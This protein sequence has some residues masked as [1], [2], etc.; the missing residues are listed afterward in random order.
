[1]AAQRMY[2]LAYPIGFL[3]SGMVYVA[4]CEVWPVPGGVSVREH[5]KV[6]GARVVG[7]GY[8]GGYGQGQLDG[9]E[10]SQQTSSDIEK[11]SADFKGLRTNSNS[12]R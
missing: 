2:I 12:S 9:A 5:R 3:V 11:S 1:M 6:V 10:E 4:L 7:G 8:V